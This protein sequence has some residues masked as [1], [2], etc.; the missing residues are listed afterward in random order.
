MG[1]FRMIL[2]SSN[3]RSSVGF[4]DKVGDLWCRYTHEAVMWPIHGHYQCRICLRQYPVPW[5]EGAQLQAEIAMTKP[6]LL[7]SIARNSLSRPL[8]L[9]EE[10]P[11]RLVA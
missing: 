11:D 6:P 10:R 8:H 9:R 7:T 5:A 1:G 3:R 4:L 2:I